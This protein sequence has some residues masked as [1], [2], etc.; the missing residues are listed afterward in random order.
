MR[1]CDQFVYA[2]RH[3]CSLEIWAAR[4]GDGP[5]NERVYVSCKARALQ[6]WKEGHPETKA[7]RTG[8][9]STPDELGRLAPAPFSS[10]SDPG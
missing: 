1:D 7:P 9:D 4:T 8:C 3:N 5:Q 10:G 6:L 2:V